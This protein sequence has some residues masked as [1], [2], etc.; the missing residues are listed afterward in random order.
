M[1][2]SKEISLYVEETQSNAKLSF[3]SHFVC[4]LIIFLVTHF[5]TINV[6]C[7]YS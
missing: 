6:T 2:G 4:D 1:I 5:A 7:G 3:A